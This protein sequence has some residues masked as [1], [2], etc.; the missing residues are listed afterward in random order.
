MDDSKE[1]SFGPCFRQPEGDRLGL[2]AVLVSVGLEV[3]P[4]GVALKQQ[5]LQPS[6]QVFLIDEPGGSVGLG[7]AHL[8]TYL[9]WPPDI[10]IGGQRLAAG[11]VRHTQ[12][13]QATTLMASFIPPI[14]EDGVSQV[15]FLPPRTSHRQNVVRLIRI[16]LCSTPLENFALTD[17]LT[18]SSRTVKKRHA[19]VRPPE[20]ATSKSSN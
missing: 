10:G 7:G 5:T 2:G 14:T 3:H 13:C 19:R 15:S 20:T 6:D 9:F 16:P 11:P 12:V 18:D 8:L 4:D 17:R 1:I